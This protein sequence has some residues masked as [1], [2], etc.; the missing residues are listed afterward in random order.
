MEQVRRFSFP[1]CFSSMGLLSFLLCRRKA[2]KG[3]PG[4]PPAHK[5]KKKGRKLRK[6]APAPHPG[7]GAEQT[8]LL[9]GCDNAGKSTLMEGLCGRTRDGVTP[10]CGFNKST[11]VV[12]NQRLRIFDVGGGANIRGIWESYYADAHG[13]IFVVDTAEGERFGEA[14]GLLQAAYAHAY[15]SGKPL[16]IVGNKADLPQAVGPDELADALQ[17]HDLLAG[18]HRVCRAIG[19][20]DPIVGGDAVLGLAASLAWL[21]ATVRADFE[22][23][24]S[25][26]AQQVAE[27]EETDRQRKEERKV[28]L[29]AKRAA[30]EQAYA[31]EAAQA[32]AAAAAA[33]DAAE[34]S[35]NAAEASPNAAAADVAAAS[36][37]SPAPSPPASVSAGDYWYASDGIGVGLPIS[38]TPMAC[39]T[40]WSRAVKLERSPYLVARMLAQPDVLHATPPSPSRLL[41]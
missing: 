8:W 3:P 18:E 9:L 25:R 24:Q 35:P 6:V 40:Y 15:L 17:A 10:T 37:P 7:E 5:P 38:D 20:S 33:K 14:R 31:E 26:C 27:Q 16:L 32:A 11:A 36:V 4:L 34:A 29:A 41:V 12:C 22:T 30:R 23:L 19:I 2:E 1:H 21:A 39:H 13:V 28:R